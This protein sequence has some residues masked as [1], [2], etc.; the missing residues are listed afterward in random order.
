M[1]VWRPLAKK[2][3]TNERDKRTFFFSLVVGRYYRRHD[4]SI[5]L[6]AHRELYFNGLILLRE[7]RK[8]G[9]KGKGSDGKGRWGI[10]EEGEGEVEWLGKGMEGGRE[11][12]KERLE[13]R[14]LNFDEF[15][16]YFEPWQLCR[17]RRIFT[18]RCTLVQSA[19][20]RS[21]VVCLSICLSVTLRYCD[22]IG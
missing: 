6:L 14:I 22:Y 4:N 20:L 1:R 8:G 19:V 11:G 7:G 13:R 3:A 15:C 17:W 2:S 10:G 21:H 5:L 16:I 18:A 9:Q 12:E